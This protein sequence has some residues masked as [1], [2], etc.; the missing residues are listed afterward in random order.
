MDR[1]EYERLF[2]ATGLD[3]GADALAFDRVDTDGDG[4]VSRE[5]LRAAAVS[6]R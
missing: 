1:A 3:T 2:G 5:E 4:S 6:A